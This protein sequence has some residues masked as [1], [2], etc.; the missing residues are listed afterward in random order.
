MLD[1]KVSYAYVGFYTNAVFD[2]LGVV[3]DCLDTTFKERSD[4]LLAKARGQGYKNY[5]L[6]TGNGVIPDFNVGWPSLVLR[7]CLV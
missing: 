2:S 5:G 3:T 7:D 6:A 4:L 1:G